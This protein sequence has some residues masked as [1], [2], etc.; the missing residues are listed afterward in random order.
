MTEQKNLKQK[1]RLW[2]DDYLLHKDE[3]KKEPSP[4]AKKRRRKGIIIS[5]IL[6]AVLI[7]VIVGVCIPMIRFLQNTDSA[8]LRDYFDQLGFEAVIIFFLINILQTMTT[9]VPDGPFEIAAGAIFGV[10]LGTLINDLAVTAG[11]LIAFTLSRC[12]GMKFVTLFVDEDKIEAHNLRHMSVKK[13]LF[14]SIAFLIPGFPKDIFTYLLGMSDMNPV[15]FTLMVF[16]CRLPGIALTVLSGDALA[17]QRR[18]EVILLWV[19]MLVILCAGVVLY[20][21]LDHRNRLKQQE[22]KQNDET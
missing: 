2:I 21:W 20:S 18:K 9:V 1:I 14:V 13:T 3:P 5:C 15:L 17:D 19:L 22:G 7:A 12:F 11:S 6:V 4:E 10:G 8:T 16:V